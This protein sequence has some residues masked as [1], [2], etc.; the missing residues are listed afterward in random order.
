MRS[1]VTSLDCEHSPGDDEIVPKQTVVLTMLQAFENRHIDGPRRLMHRRLI[2]KSP[3]T[4]IST[5]PKLST[6][7]AQ[8]DQYLD[9][10]NS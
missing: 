3:L 10:I 7:N 1:K 2:Q 5:R 6:N 4:L 8:R 9:K